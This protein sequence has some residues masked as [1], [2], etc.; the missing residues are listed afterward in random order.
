MIILRH[1]KKNNYP[2]SEIIKFDRKSRKNN[3][4]IFGLTISE[5]T[6]VITVVIWKMKELLNIEIAV[7]DINL[8][9]ITTTQKLLQLKSRY[10]LCRI[11]VIKTDRTIKFLGN[12]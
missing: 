5:N 1:E 4:L 11:Y 2:E 3:I 6:N 8:Y 12:T 9:P 10:T 7:N